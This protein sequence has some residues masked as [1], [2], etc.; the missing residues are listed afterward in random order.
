MFLR[1]NVQPCGAVYA[2]ARIPA[3]VG[4][5]RVERQYAHD[6]FAAE[7]DVVLHFDKK[8]RIAVFAPA[9]QH[10]VYVYLR[11]A[12]N[13]FE[14]KH[15]F[16]APP[17]FGSEKAFLIEIVATPEP[18]CAL[19]ARLAERTGLAQHGVVRQTYDRRSA[20]SDATE[21]PALV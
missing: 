4:L 8:P 9:R 1:Q 19:A 20:F 2:R 15:H 13:A 11:V 10:A 18:A 16:A 17:L 5:G 3:A 7:R 14:F 21:L 6:V 12:V